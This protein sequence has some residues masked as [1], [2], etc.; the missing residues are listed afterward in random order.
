MQRRI[1]AFA[2]VGVVIILAAGTF[3]LFSRGQPITTHKAAGAATEVGTAVPTDG[4]TK[5]TLDASRSSASY[6]VHE[7]LILGGVGSHTAVGTSHTVSGSLYLGLSGNHP[8]LTEVNVS[9][10]LTS[11]TT[12]NPLR[13]QHVQDYLDTREFPNAQFS[14]TNVSGLPATYT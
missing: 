11:L 10:D 8:V 1:I 5:Y 3:V 6:S 12:D 14:S 7:N 4:L 13:D 2:A 9:V